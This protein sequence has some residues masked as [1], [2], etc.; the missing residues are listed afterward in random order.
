MQ[1]EEASQATVNLSRQKMESL[2][3]LAGGIAHDF[4][5]LLGTILADAELAL[6]ELPPGSPVGIEIQHIRTVAIRASEIVREL[7]VYAGQDVASVEPVDLSRLV[8]EMLQ[9]LKASIPKYAVL[10]TDFEKGLPAVLSNAPQLRQVVMNL[11]IN[12]AEALGPE[13][14]FIHVATSHLNSRDAS[15][16][17]Q[18][19]TVPEGGYVCLEVSDTGCG[20][21]PELQEHIFDPFFTTKVAGRG[22]GLAVVHAI[23]ASYGGS[24]QVRSTPGQGT[25]FAILFPSSAQGGQP[26]V[27]G[28]GELAGENGAPMTGNL[29]VVEDEEGLRIAVSKMLRKTGLSVIEASDGWTA[30][31]LIRNREQAID[32]ILLDMTIPGASSYEVFTEAQRV[33]PGVKIVIT[34]AY[35][36][37]AAGGS[38]DGPELKGFIRK[39]YQFADLMELLRKALAG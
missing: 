28:A 24:I 18:P 34:T 39:P 6:A 3:I 26:D 23:V 5:N 32:L 15:S 19:C 35:A 29:L 2:G 36:R 21:S 16:K 38:F 30:T 8:E 17:D 13:G 20:M 22:Q 7:M 27:G 11:I 1:V 10:T 33:R 25:R 12:A 4:N 14:G 9:L 37:E 31:D